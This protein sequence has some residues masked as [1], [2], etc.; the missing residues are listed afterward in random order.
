MVEESLPD[1]RA[2]D[3]KEIIFFSWY[4]KEHYHSGIGLMTPESLRYGMAEEVLTRRTIVLAEAYEK[5]PNRFKSKMPKPS[6]LPEAV[7][8]NKRIF[9]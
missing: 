7:W 6:P 4:N 1:Y 2:G 5:H 9:D 3:F 8:V